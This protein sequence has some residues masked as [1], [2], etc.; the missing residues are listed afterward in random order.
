[1]TEEDKIKPVSSPGLAFNDIIFEQICDDVNGNHFLV[2]D[3]V[4]QQFKI[5]NNDVWRSYSVNSIEYFPLEK[6]PWPRV[7]GYENFNIE[8]LYQE[9]RAFFVEHLDVTNELFYDVYACYVL[10][11]WRIEDFKVIPYLFFLGPLSSGK[12]RALE[13]FSYLCYRSIL[14][15]SISAASI[16]RVLEAWHPTLLLDE[17]EIYNRES[18]IEV[19]A[20]LNSGY[21]KGQ[22]AIRIEREK[23]GCP[24]IGMFDTFGFKVLAGTKELAAT[25]QSRCIIT[26]MSRAVKP[27]NLFIDEEKAQ[28]LRNQLLQ[29]RFKN[30]GKTENFN[31][32][33][34][35]KNNSFYRNSRV[36]EIFISLIQVAPN[37][38]IKKKLKDCMK[39]ITKSRLDEEQASIEA[40]IFFTILRCK[41]ENGKISTQNIVDIYNLDLTEKEKVTSRFIGRKVA[42]LGFEKCRVGSK[43]QA[44]FY[45]NE[46][47][48]ER[49]NSRYDPKTTSETSE[50]TETTVSKE[51]RQEKQVSN[52]EV[53]EHKSSVENE[54]KKENLTVNTEVSEETEVTEVSLRPILYFKRLA[55]N[56]LRPCDG[57]GK[58]NPCPHLAEY[59]MLSSETPTAYCESHFQATRKACIDNGFELVEERLSKHD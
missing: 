52:T 48:I 8:E 15:A 40:T 20:L 34:F 58:G 24:Q 46:Q 32:A 1:M 44:G 56:K 13:C 55:P 41:P 11:S 6:L 9:I 17:T 25:L 30:L 22:Y 28:S 16:F 5:K 19:L 10:A 2:Y 50:T 54:P 12:T 27:V 45:W 21:R 35:A 4:E 49:L 47:L 23:E 42:A 38:E 3:R 53:T 43:G 33:E 26:A 39:Q 18:M 14:S 36:I 37:E 29:Y 51:K 31:L 59:E 57:E 7:T